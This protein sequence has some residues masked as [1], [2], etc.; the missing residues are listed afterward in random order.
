MSI[1]LPKFSQLSEIRQK[2]VKMRAEGITFD[3]IAA[4]LETPYPTIRDWLTEWNGSCQEELTEY[5]AYLADKQIESTE[6]FQKTIAKDAEAVWSRLKAIA[7]S[8][9]ASMPKHVSL[10]ALDSMLDRMGVARVSKTEGKLGLTVTEEDRRK[11]WDEIRNLQS[12]IEPVQL[13]QLAGGK[14]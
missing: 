7:L 1:N 3:A 12:Q 6:N 10:A 11:R 14:V 13:K 2:A 5:K 4:E 8:D 9:D